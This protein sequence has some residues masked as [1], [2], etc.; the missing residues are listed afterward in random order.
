MIII[1]HNFYIYV[2]LEFSLKLIIPNIIIIIKIESSTKYIVNE[3]IYNQIGH[4]AY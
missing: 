1:K 2:L 3:I 4:L